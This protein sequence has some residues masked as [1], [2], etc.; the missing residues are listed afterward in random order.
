[1][2]KTMN[3]NDYREDFAAW[4]KDCVMIT[5]KESGARVPFALNAPQRRVAG[6]LER[7][8]REGRPIRLIMLKARQWGGST[9]VQIY[10]AWMQL[11]RHTGW[12]SVIC[13]H[14][15][16]ASAIIR[17]MYSDLLRFYPDGMK[18]DGKPRD[19]AFAPYEKSPNINYIAARDCRVAI[20]SSFAPNAVRGGNYQMAHLSEVAFWGDGEQDAAE[21][22]VR[23]VAGSITLAPETLVVMESTADGEDNYFHTEWER[24]VRG[25]S[26]KE[27]VFV[28]WYEIEIYRKP[29]DEAGLRRLMTEMDDYERQLL[30]REG[31]TAEAV[32]WYH[33]K[34]REY[35]RHEQMMAEYPSTPD[36]AFLRGGGE[37]LDPAWFF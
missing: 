18:T 16:D 30:K 22:I 21:Q 24:A 1:M 2:L 12:N 14:V 4:C 25:E 20:G 28:P 29:L 33:D 5:D 7:Q 35:T 26:D 36:E 10:M 37:V 32:A 8:R 23:S 6:I 34:R 11:V 17:G 27:A 13:S 15:K 3:I 19:W 31:V 9:L